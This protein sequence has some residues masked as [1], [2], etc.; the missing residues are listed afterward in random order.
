MVE[1]D[2]GISRHAVKLNL[3]TDSWVNQTLLSEKDWQQIRPGHG[4]RKPKLKKNK[5]NFTPSGTKIKLPILRKNKVSVNSRM[6]KT[7]NHKNVCRG[8]RNTLFLLLHI[9]Y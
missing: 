1:L 6:W 3:L 7:D 4:R 5:T 9:H 2:H 8:C